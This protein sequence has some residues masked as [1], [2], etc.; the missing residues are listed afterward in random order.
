MRNLFL[1]LFAT[2]FVSTVAVARRRRLR[3]A[4]RRGPGYSISLRVAQWRLGC[5]WNRLY[6]GSRDTLL[7]Q[8]PKAVHVQ[9]VGCFDR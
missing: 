4:R 6:M 9:T 2:V 8:R 1:S 3:R 7:Q 5:H